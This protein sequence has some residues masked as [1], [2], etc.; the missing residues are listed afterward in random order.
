MNDTDKLKPCPFCGGQAILY[1]SPQGGICVMCWKCRVQTP[2]RVDCL[3]FT[4][5]TNATKQA[6]EAWNRRITE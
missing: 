2:N 1:V 3:D 5:P 4:K 6:I